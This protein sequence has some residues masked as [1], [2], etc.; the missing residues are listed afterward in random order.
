MAFMPNALRSALVLALA[1]ARLSGQAAPSQ[2]PADLIITNARIY[3]VDDSRPVVEAF[4]V[5]GG[6]VAF[7]GDA[8]GALALRGPQTQVLD[9]GGRT[10]I[11]GMVDAHGHVSGL[12]TALAI[13]DLTG[14]SSYD[15]IIA[16][17][18]A[19]ARTVAPGV[20]VTGRGWDQNRWADTR[21]PSHVKLT[22]AV[23][24]NPVLLERVDGHANLANRMAMDAAGVTP[25]TKDP[26]GGRIE[27][28]ADGS[29]SGVFVDNAQG[30]MQRAVPRPSREELKREVVNAIAET[31][32][33]GLT[34]V[35]DAGEGQGVLDIYEEL[36]RAGELNSR[37]YAMISD[38]SA[39]VAR[40]FA[41][42]PQS[43]LYGGTLWIRSI[44][45]YAD[46][47][48]GSRGAALLE[49]YSDDPG[50]TGLLIST[51]A[52]LQDVATRALRAGFQVCIHAIGDRGNRVA[53][54]AYEAAL[55][56]VPT[57]DHRFRIEHAQNLHYLD[58]PRFA[59]LGVIPSMQA[60]HQSSDMYWVGT[61]LG[62]SRLVEAY[63]W[64]A[65]LNTGIVIPNGSDFPV[66]RVNPLI[67]FHA[68][69]S[70]QDANNYPPGGWQPE[71]VMTRDEALKSMTIWPA[72]AAFQ[73]HDL[74]SLTA[75]KYADFVVL[76]Q[77]IMRAPV[78]TILATRVLS[79]WVG[80]KMVYEAK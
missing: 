9:L 15:E 80:G 41:R 35:H 2:P 45:L 72:F 68:A 58:I 61:R 52:H 54:D 77:D 3:T 53:L 70:R 26:A 24:N 25:A 19:K 37:I 42:G 39:A 34:G 21:F 46:G 32:R 30:I 5:R 76:D 48:M 13:V 18:A 43:A 74:G 49:P 8:R 79:T 64:R 28:H 66:E 69:V 65:L 50:N 51:Q 4:A 20:W 33:W 10:V 22:A 59:K 17:V 44:K 16:R 60:S 55:G 12:G 6:R 27:H 56:A 63:P 67:S 23:P 75:G 40:A 71:Q 57:A 7:A 11:P 29:P 47:A 1:T 14:A 73:E 31:Q 78:E 62:A 38:D 36:G